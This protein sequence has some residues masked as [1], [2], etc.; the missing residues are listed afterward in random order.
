MSD[1]GAPVRLGLVGCGRLASSG[2]LPALALCS[3]V[4]LAAVTDLD[5]DRATALVAEAAAAG[6]GEVVVARSIAELVA[7]GPLDGVLVATPVAAH[8]GDAQD[9]AAAGLP[10]LVEK[11][12]APDAASAAELAKLEPTPFVA[13]N[14]RFDPG[15]RAV[16]A[17]IGSRARGGGVLEVEAAIT[18]RRGSWGAHTV[19]D[20]AL[21][22]LGPHLV[23]WVRWSTGAEILR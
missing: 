17:A 1:Q 14:R 12:P 9:I 3:G 13:F 18:Y 8:L 11:P 4:R 23:D 10:V 19:T 15:A 2:Y 22:D 5:T 6:H 16:R 7:A 21:L 20:D